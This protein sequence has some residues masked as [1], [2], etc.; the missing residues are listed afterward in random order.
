MGGGG[1]M[2]DAINVMKRNKS[3]KTSGK[4]GFKG[5]YIEKEDYNPE[6]ATQLDFSF[7]TNEQVQAEN[8]RIQKRLRLRKKKQIIAFFMIVF[9]L[10]FSIWL[11]AFSL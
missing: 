8:S 1:F 5:T 2:Q 9:L 3:Q 11:L 7:A 10:C 6:N 4:Q